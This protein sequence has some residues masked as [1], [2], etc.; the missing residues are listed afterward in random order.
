LFG[1]IADW[2]PLSHLGE[3]SPR[4]MWLGLIIAILI[5]WGIV[6]LLYFDVIH[7][8]YH[9]TG[10]F[11]FHQGGD[12]DSYFAL[13][14]SIL[15]GHPI[16]S[17][18]TLGYPLLLIPWIVVF[19]PASSTSLIPPIAIF[20]AFVLFPL[21]QGIFLTL[22]AR[23][24]RR[25]LVA[26]AA[27][28]LWTVLPILLYIGLALVN[29]VQLG[30]LWAGHLVW[31]QML[32]DPP[33][34]FLTLLSFWLLFRLIDSAVPRRELGWAAALGAACGLLLLIRINSVLSVGV[35]LL[36]LTVSRRWRALALVIGLSIVFFCPQLVYNAA[37]FGSPF[38]VGYVVFDQTSQGLMNF[39]YPLKVL[40][41]RYAFLAWGGLFSLAVLMGG[42]L[43]ALWRAD[44]IGTLIIGLWAAGYLAFFSLYY[45]SWTGSLFRFLIPVYPAYALLTVSLLLYRKD[46]PRP[47]TPG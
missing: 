19:Q 36:V 40:T 31:L 46:R 32:S 17:Q 24:T 34:T 13:A 37:N 11:I 3:I 30:A 9:Q 29:H 43:Y 2:N 1:K 26:L 39:I 18:F 8:P 22:A 44:R 27:L 4:R 7:D 6:A 33:A 5:Q 20:H 28:F 10:T 45:Y 41:S 25:R 35:V 12:Q 21:S 14:R 23:I 42:G 15:D 38:A 47:G 16:R